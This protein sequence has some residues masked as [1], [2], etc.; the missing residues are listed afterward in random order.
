MSKQIIWGTEKR[1]V[2]ELIPAG[3]NPRVIGE[4][5]KADLM[6]SVVEFGKVIPV[7]I[8]SGKRNNRLIGG[9]QR[10]QIYADLGEGDH[11]IEVRVP[12]RELSESEEKELNI[13]LNKNTGSWDMDKLVKNFK[14]DDLTGWGFVDTDLKSWFGLSEA[15]ETDVEEDRMAILSVFPPEASL[16]RE[17]VAVKFTAKN[18]YD[19]VKEWIKTNG[20]SAAANLLLNAAKG[21]K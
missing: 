18:D 5:E 16:L 3:Y 20:A 8:N 1:K 12:N 2:S 6:A 19:M 11:E 17:K 13:R 21:Q 4:K 9:H 10:V 14:M 15:Q 7:V